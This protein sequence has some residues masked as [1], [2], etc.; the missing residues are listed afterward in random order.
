MVCDMRGKRITPIRA[1]GDVR[2]QTGRWVIGTGDQTT[3]GLIV[4]HSATVA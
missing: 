1:Q 3:P 2:R 4:L